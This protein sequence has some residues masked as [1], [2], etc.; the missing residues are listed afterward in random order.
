MEFIRNPAYKPVRLYICCYQ[1][2]L[3][4]IPVVYRLLQYRITSTPVIHY[5]LM[6]IPVAT[7]QNHVYTCDTLQTDVYTC[8]YDTESRLHL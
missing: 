3:M 8:S 7:I 6:S 4:S 2:R 5:R 1:Y